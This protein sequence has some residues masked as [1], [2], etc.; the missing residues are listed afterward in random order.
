MASRLSKSFTQQ[1]SLIKAFNSLWPTETLTWADATDLS[2]ARW[3]GSALSVDEHVPK[4]VKLDAIRHHHL[5]LRCDEEIQLFKEEMKSTLSFYLRDWQQLFAG[6]EEL[7]HTRY[8]NGALSC[9]QLARLQC[10]GTL[11]DLM[12]SFSQ[13]V[14]LNGDFLPLDKFLLLDLRLD[15]QAQGEDESCKH[16]C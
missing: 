2:S 11:Q 15:E 10:E 4:Q 5:L 1:S 3:I 7:P 6:I 9:L 14:D 13:F 12:S 16:D 8:N